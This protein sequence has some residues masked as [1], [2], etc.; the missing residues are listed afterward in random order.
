MF[1]MDSYDNYA[2]IILLFRAAFQY[3]L[4]MA[5][6]RKTRRAALGKKDEKAELDREWQKIRQVRVFP[7]I[8]L[9]SPLFLCNYV[10][11]NLILCFSDYPKIGWQV[12]CFYLHLIVHMMRI[13]FRYSY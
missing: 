1:S 4:K 11:H 13:F 3:G 5:D 8:S 12:Q 9:F 10:N 7:P 6:G 2:I